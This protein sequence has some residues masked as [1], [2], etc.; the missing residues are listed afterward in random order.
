MRKT[1]ILLTVLLAIVPFMGCNQASLSETFYLGGIQVNEP[2]NRNWIKTLKSTGMNTI[3]VTVYA[4]QEEWDSDAIWFDSPQDNKGVISEI[5][6]AKA[7][8]LRVV[9]ILRIA[10]DHA[11]ER[12]AF[13]WH[14][15]IMPSSD[16]ELQS[17]FE[18]YGEF[19]RGWAAIAEA[20]GVDALGIGSE[21]N[22]LTS[23]KPVQQLPQLEDYY[24]DE[25]KQQ[26]RI[27]DLLDNQDQISEEQLSAWG[28]RRF[29][30]LES[31]LQSELSAQQAWARKVSWQEFP[32]PIAHINQRR[33]L[34]EYHWRQLIR[35]VREKY[36][37]QITYAANFDQY[38]QVGFW[39]TLDF[40]GINAYFPLRSKLV[41]HKISENLQTTLNAS[42]LTILNEIEAYRQ[43]ESITDKPVIFTELG[44]A[45]WENSTIEPWAYT[46]FSLVNTDNQETVVVWP[47]QSLNLQE[48]ATA[49]QSLYDM[50]ELH[51]PDLLKGLLYWKLSTQPEQTKIEPYVLILDG[52]DPLQKILTQ[53]TE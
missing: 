30:N 31:L 34:L 32:A 48:R 18:K 16:Q 6:A 3:S 52:T 47:E 26:L 46:G 2:D 25:Q 43:T 40:I 51:H 21:L 19:V 17:W 15:S 22:Q 41:T 14:G 42:W 9:L 11:F 23:T 12:N 39:D 29:N 36:Q 13:L 45:R 53:F 28:D 1:L 10:L 49:F 37:G 33:H 50:L 38:Q 44:Y 4:R 5:R 7:E 8:D 27:Q 24:L 20:E 35:Q